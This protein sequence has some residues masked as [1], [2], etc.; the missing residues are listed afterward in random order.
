M[1]KPLLTIAIPY[2]EER[3]D[4][5]LKLKSEFERQIEKYN[6][7]NEVEIIS[8]ATGKE[9]PIGEKRQLLYMA[10]NGL[11]TVQWDSDDWVHSG[12]LK[13]MTDAIKVDI[14]ADA[15][16]YKEWCKMEGKDY[17]S[18][19]SN[20]YSGWYG[21]GSRLLH[22]GFHYHRNIF[23]KDP[24][25]T[26]LARSI[27]VPK[28]R[29]NEDEQFATLIAPLIKKQT[30]INEFIYIYQY[31]PKDKPEERYGFNK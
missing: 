12:G 27:E 31:E 25:N 7:Y 15:I 17:F 22:D 4:D 29:W 30:Y 9:M 18:N 5:Y 6:L 26:E 2:T 10:S 20:E 23:F 16:G 14:G 28:I 11:M 3:V 1:I 24:I 19:H 13:L 21:D 8:D